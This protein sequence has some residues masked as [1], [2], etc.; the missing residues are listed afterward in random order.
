MR[1]WL[2]SAAALALAFPAF[3]ATQAAAPE[4][5]APA[6]TPAPAPRPAIWLND[7]GG[8]AAAGKLP[9]I[10]RGAILDGFDG[11]AQAASVEAAL[12]RGQPADDAIISDSW[13]RFVGALRAAVP[14][15]SYADRALYPKPQPAAAILA[16]LTA[17]PSLSDHI[18]T[19][20]AVNPMYAAL[21]DAAIKANAANDPRVRATLDRLR[22]L[23][24]KGRAIVVDVASAQLW[25]LQ[26]GTPAETMKVVVGKTSSP[27]PLLAGTIHFI[28]FN[29][30]WH[31]LDEVVERK[32]APLVL[33]RGVK[34]LKAA[35][36]ETV[37]DWSKAEPVDPETIDW[38]AVA[39]GSEK[40]FIRQRPGANNMMGA[41][42][43]S[44]E[45][46]QDIFL[47][48]TPHRELF[49][50]A[51]RT[52]S[53]GCIRLEHAD[54]LAQWLQG[55]DASPPADTPEL[56]VQLAQGVPVYVTYLTAAVR[57]GQLAFVDDV[58]GLDTRME[59]AAA[60]AAPSRE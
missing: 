53:L 10:F 8:R 32:V 44:F 41:M 4:P 11:A 60:Q 55:S 7:N 25:A 13:V 58:Y 36:Y 21:R 9:G 47:H 31:I 52:L 54:R 38:K 27:T 50:K 6:A 43:F 48:D 14:G 15:I 49:A 17:A 18:D 28:T 37:S 57:D 35:R 59:V 56:H 22:P 40:A 26:D 12:A 51:R 5:A 34:Y 23:P 46:E 1:G 3:A 24:G 29:P 20:A 30:Y 45:N 2:G 19:V 39:A 42:K 16:Q 33:K